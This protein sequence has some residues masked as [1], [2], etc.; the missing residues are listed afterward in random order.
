[1]LLVLVASTSVAAAG[2]YCFADGGFA[3]LEGS[4]LPVKPRVVVFMG[5]TFYASKVS[6]KAAQSKVTATIDG[7]KVPVAIKSQRVGNQV[8]QSIDI[9]SDKTGELVVKMGKDDEASWTIASEWTAPEKVNA[10]VSRYRLDRAM[11][12]YSWYEGARLTLDQPALTMRAKWRRDAKDKWHTVVVPIMTT[13]SSF[14]DV[15]AVLN[16]RKDGKKPPPPTAAALL[17]EVR[18]G[19]DTIPVNLL[20]Q[21]VEIEATVM[22]PNGKEVPVAGLPNPVI[23]EKSKKQPNELLAD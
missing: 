21:G 1:V 3:P 2:P 4:T 22:L 11:R 5:D 19:T 12:N 7:K 20:E 9:K 14:V 8:I 18:C 16:D 15:E 13:R 17:G 6:K 23:I 10:T